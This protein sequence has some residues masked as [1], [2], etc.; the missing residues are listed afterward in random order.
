MSSPSVLD[1]RRAAIDIAIIRQSVARCGLIVRWAPT[2]RMLAD[3]L[4]KD[5]GDPADLLRSVLR[6]GVYQIA[7]EQVVL[8]NKAEERARRQNRGVQKAQE[9]KHKNRKHKDTQLTED[10][11]HEEPF[12]VPPPGL[13]IKIWVVHC[14][15]QVNVLV[16]GVI[17]WD[18][19]GAH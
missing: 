2:D 11:S 3:A 15:G 16:L 18:E 14:I 8:E 6:S 7:G 1:D 9:N 19:L 12:I 10:T 17:H 13:C 4:T 5:K